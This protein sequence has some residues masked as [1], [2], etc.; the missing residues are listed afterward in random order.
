[1]GFKLDGFVGINPLVDGGRED[2]LLRFGRDG[3]LIVHESHG[4]FYEACVRGQGFVATSGTPLQFLVAALAGPHQC[5]WNPSG[6]GVM[7][8]IVK[9]QL[10]KTIDTPDAPSAFQWRITQPAGAEPGTAGPITAGTNIPPVN[11]LLGSGR[12]S[13]ARYSQDTAYAAAPTY[14]M[15]MGISQDTWT[16]ASTYPP[17]TYNIDYDGM[18]LVPPNSAVSITAT[19]LTGGLYFL[20]IFFIESAYPGTMGA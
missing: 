11:L 7:V 5:L 4:K 16:A 3:S 17:M 12:V 19:V 14:L 13:K 8:E 6:S 1:M 2:N 20:N 15:G 18:F 9:V 10:T